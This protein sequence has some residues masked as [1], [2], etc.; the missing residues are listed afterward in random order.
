MNMKKII[1]NYTEEI[2]STMLHGEGSP[3]SSLWCT[4]CAGVFTPCDNQSLRTLRPKK[5]ESE[6]EGKSVFMCT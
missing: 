4:E 1:T 5:G 3:A 6:F 2:L